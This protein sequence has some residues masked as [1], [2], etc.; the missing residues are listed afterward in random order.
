MTKTIDPCVLETVSGGAS[1]DRH[2]PPLGF[3]P[4]PQLLA[5][6]LGEVSRRELAFGMAQCSVPQPTKKMINEEA[7]RAVPK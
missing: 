7:R 4:C 5:K 3:G 6:P 1:G 2:P